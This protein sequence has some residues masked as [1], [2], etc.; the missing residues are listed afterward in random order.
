MSVLAQNHLEHTFFQVDL[1]CVLIPAS[2]FDQAAKMSDPSG[3]SIV[4][5]TFSLRQTYIQ[6]MHYFNLCKAIK[7]HLLNLHFLTD[8]EECL[9]NLFIIVMA[10]TEA[11]V[12]TNSHQIATWGQMTWFASPIPL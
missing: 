11:V 8:Y 9:V 10:G 3:G 5:D 2:Y 12:L 4:K 6:V 1:H 7:Y